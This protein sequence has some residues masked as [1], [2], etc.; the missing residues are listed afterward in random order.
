MFPELAE[1]E[2]PKTGLSTQRAPS[3]FSG[4]PLPPLPPP[5]E[6]P[7][8][9]DSGNHAHS[10]A[11]VHYYTEV[12]EDDNRPAYVQA[13][14]Y[15]IPKEPTTPKPIFK[16]NRDFEKLAIQPSTL[17]LAASA[18]VSHRNLELVS[19]QDVYNSEES[20][21]CD[22][23]AFFPDVETNDCK[24]IV[25]VCNEATDSDEPYVEVLEKNDHTFNNQAIVRKTKHEGL[26]TYSKSETYLPVEKASNL[27]PSDVMTA[28]VPRDNLKVDIT[29]GGRFDNQPPY[30]GNL[31]YFPR[32]APS[33]RVCDEYV[34]D[35]TAWVE[36]EKQAEENKAG[37]KIYKTSIF[38]TVSSSALE[39]KVL[40]N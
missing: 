1:L 36:P 15:A 40:R 38:V 7:P 25:S 34:C 3:V 2:E 16:S 13:Q 19:D 20:P 5:R 18:T 22:N 6:Q 30:N 35:Q 31:G 29:H 8:Q 23:I 12:I 21:Y 33:E 28:N 26:T 10:D 4:R 32:F 11:D 37:A 14:I 39:L 24:G 27:L 9:E 17:N